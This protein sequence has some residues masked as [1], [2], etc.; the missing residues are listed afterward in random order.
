V[1][2]VPVC[3]ETSIRIARGATRQMLFIGTG[4]RLNSAIHT[5]EPVC[6]VEITHSADGKV[7]VT[8]RDVPFNCAVEFERG[9]DRWNGFRSYTTYT[10]IAANKKVNLLASQRSGGVWSLKFVG[11]HYRLVI[12][13]GETLNV[14]HK[15]G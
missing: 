1:D 3:T 2:A 7:S 10:S 11:R 12:R 4:E 13:P 5:R 6:S 14:T 9:G 15:A 8:C